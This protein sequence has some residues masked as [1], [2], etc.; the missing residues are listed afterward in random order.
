[1][2]SCIQDFGYETGCSALTLGTSNAND[3]RGAF[4]EKLTSSSAAATIA[5]RTFILCEL[6]FIRDDLSR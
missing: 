5:M 3:G 2:P 6:F 1:M 4:G